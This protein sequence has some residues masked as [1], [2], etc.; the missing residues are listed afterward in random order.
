MRWGAS[1]PSFRCPSSS[2]KNPIVHVLCGPLCP[3]LRGQSGV[4]NGL[5]E[6][7]R[8]LVP[9][10]TLPCP[11]G[12][13]ANL[14]DGVRSGRFRGG[15]EMETFR[16]QASK[17]S[18]LQAQCSPLC[19]SVPPA[20]EIPPIQKQALPAAAEKSSLNL[21]RPGL[22]LCQNMT[23]PKSLR[24]GLDV[25]LAS[26]VPSLEHFASLP[27]VPKPLPSMALPGVLAAHLQLASPK[28]TEGHV[29]PVR[30]CLQ[31]EVTLSNQERC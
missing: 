31:G 6:K 4:W 20:V 30:R 14:R 24:P 10:P 21:R 27:Q 15:W 1:S 13:E 26:Q 11:S 7:G 29:G 18:E 9:D 3:V 28:R 12:R 25:P 5:G 22:G 17:E 2:E 23:P 16:G 19:E 8:A